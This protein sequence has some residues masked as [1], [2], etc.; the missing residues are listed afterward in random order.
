MKRLFF[1]TAAILAT[2]I[3]GISNMNAENK[4]ASERPASVEAAISDSELDAS[5]LLDAL[6]AGAEAASPEARIESLTEMENLLSDSVLGNEALES[7]IDASLEE[8]SLP[9]ADELIADSAIDA[10]TALQALAD[11]IAR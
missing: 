3:F 2:A 8:R 4:N 7:W 9:A 11:A 10:E 5:E 6:N 1:T